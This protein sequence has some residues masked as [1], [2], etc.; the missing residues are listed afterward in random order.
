MILKID[1]EGDEYNI[2][3]QILNN[4]KKINTLLIEFH[5]IQK[6]MNLIKEFIEKSSDLKLIHIHGNNHSC[7]DK[8]IDP[9]IIELT[10]TNIE[11]IKFEQKITAKKYPI[12]KLDYKNVYRKNDFILR[13]E[14]DVKKP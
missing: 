2:L 12:E 6:N 10:F 11:K 4:L 5:D 14:G 13:F 3:K 1:I 8:N 9:N 7:V